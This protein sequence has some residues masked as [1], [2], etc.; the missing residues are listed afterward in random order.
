MLDSRF[1]NAIFFDV[2][3]TE[4]E[5]FERANIGDGLGRH[6][7]LPPFSAL[8]FFSNLDSEPSYCSFASLTILRFASRIAELN[9]E[10]QPNAN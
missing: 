7:C 2:R 9:F 8:L 4:K 10:M 3:I 1:H 5:D 6:S